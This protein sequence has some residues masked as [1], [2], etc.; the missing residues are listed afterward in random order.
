MDL[1]IK[2]QDFLGQVIELRLPLAKSDSIYQHSNSST[3]KT[4][5]KF[6]HRGGAIA[7][8]EKKDSLKYSGIINFQRHLS[9]IDREATYNLLAIQNQKK[10]DLS[11]TQTFNN[12]DYPASMIA[13]QLEMNNSNWKALI[14]KLEGRELYERTLSIFFDPD[15]VNIS[16]YREVERGGEKKLYITIHPLGFVLR[17][18]IYWLPEAGLPIEVNISGEIDENFGF[19]G[20]DKLYPVTE[21]RL[22]YLSSE[23]SS[24]SNYSYDTEEHKRGNQSIKRLMLA[25]ELLQGVSAWTTGANSIADVNLKWDLIIK[26]N[27]RCY[28][29][30]IKSNS[31]SAM[32]AYE[33]YFE[34][35]KRAE[36]P[37]IPVIFWT[38][39]GSYINKMAQCF[40]KLFNVPLKSN[41]TSSSS[42]VVAT[43]INLQK[44][45]NH[46]DDVGTGKK[47][48][49]DIVIALLDAAGRGEW[50]K[51]AEDLLQAIVDRGKNTHYQLINHCRTIAKARLK[52]AE[53]LEG[54]LENTQQQL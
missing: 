51:K 48:H 14:N 8:T 12:I 28:P 18:E 39:S 19:C 22:D 52:Q 17:P 49:K 6:A 5:Y 10:L 32:E 31:E 43:D 9:L 11:K 21:K 40:A 46:I 47:A 2:L 35:W 33:E 4:T 7:V 3:S 44:K 37:F 50:D 13:Y 53:F 25:L 38:N 27:N 42:E 41:E 23:Y 20:G 26:V 34:L 15:T 30:Q 1:D 16:N 36:I 54:N 24:S 29:L 45:Y